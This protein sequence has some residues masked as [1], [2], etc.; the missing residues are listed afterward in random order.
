MK[1]YAGYFL[2]GLASQGCILNWETQE[3]IYVPE[4]P[5]KANYYC[6]TVPEDLAPYQQIVDS[7]PNLKNT[8]NFCTY[9]ESVLQETM[10][11]KVREAELTGLPPT[12]SLPTAYEKIIPADLYDKNPITKIYVTQEEAHE[13]YAAHLAHS[14]WLEKNQIVPWSLQ[15]YSQEQLKEIV[16]PQAFFYSWS[17]QQEI[18][19][20]SLLLNHSPRESFSIA[21]QAESFSDQKTAIIEIVKQLRSYKHGTL[22]ID[23]REITT[24]KEMSEEK[25]SRHGCHTTS[26]FLVQAAKSLNIPGRYIIG[27]YAEG[28][29]RSAIFEFTDQV[30][31]HGD[32]P[33]N[34]L[35]SDTPSAELMDSFTYWEDEVLSQEKG[36]PQG[37]HNSMVHNYENGMKYPSRTLLKNYCSGGF[38]EL[39]QRFIY[40]KYGAFAT[41]DQLKDLEQK[42]LQI[43]NNCTIFPEDNPD[44][45]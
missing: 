37:A 35:V 10:W 3:D 7:I 33:Y 26:L 41:I 40:T 15:E 14:L 13:I 34:R 22:H 42:I 6:L 21:A 23:P 30:L 25:I 2:V 8:I 18:Y 9:S 20:S 19:A 12:A 36:D 31:A 17:D 11:E 1:R 43:S 45:K 27:Y 24:L 38:T 28:G 39:E 44:Q 29:H 5:K 16:R 32:D 4:N